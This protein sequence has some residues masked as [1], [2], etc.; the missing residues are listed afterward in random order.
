ML[1]KIASI[2]IDYMHT[3]IGFIASE[4]FGENLNIIHRTPDTTIWYTKDQ[5][6]AT[7]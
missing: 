7:K 3:R 5:M 2:Q 1:W 6:L 4:L